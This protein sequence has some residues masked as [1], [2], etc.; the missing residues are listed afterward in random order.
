MLIILF[1]ILHTYKYIFKLITNYY[2]KKIYRNQE[3]LDISILS[4]FE[5]HFNKNY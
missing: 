4:D 3:K 1:I 5:V 2:T